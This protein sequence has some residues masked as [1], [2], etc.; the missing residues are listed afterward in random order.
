MSQQG[1]ALYNNAMLFKL[2]ADIDT[3]RLA[4]A[5]EAVV[6]AH[7]Y[8]K[9]RLFIDDEGHPRQRRNDEEPYQQSIEHLRERD[10]LKLKPQLEQPFLLLSDQLFR[11]RIIKTEENVYLFIDF[12]HIIFDGTSL[13]VLLADL[14]KAYRGESIERETFSGFEIAQEEEILRQTNAYSDAKKWNL[15]MFGDLEITSLPLSDKSEQTISFGRQQLDL[16]LEESELKQICSLLNVTP[17]IFTISV[18]GYLLGYYNYSHESLFATIYH[19]RHDLKTNH[20][21]SMMVKTLPRGDCNSLS[22]PK[23][24]ENITKIATS[25]MMALPIPKIRF[26]FLFIIKPTSD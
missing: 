13:N 21:I 22:A 3:D 9:T 14:N 20:T 12:H 5:F 6:Q 10:F 19:G 23:P 11:I 7:P 25:A 2:A 1:K 18:F 17:N 8:I 16:G 24:V 26:I 4:R 15:Q